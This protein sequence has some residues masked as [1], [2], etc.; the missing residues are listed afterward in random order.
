[1]ILLRRNAI[2][3]A[4]KNQHLVGRSMEDVFNHTVTHVIP[5]PV[6][7]REVRRIYLNELHK[8]GSIDDV[9]AIIHAEYYDVVA[10]D[11]NVT[12]AAIKSIAYFPE[13]ITSHPIGQSATKLS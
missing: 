11:N 4:A 6:G 1:M 10:V 13:A 8:N 2:E 7:S 3:L 9:L 12:P 5:L